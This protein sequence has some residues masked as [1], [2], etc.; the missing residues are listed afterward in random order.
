MMFEAIQ[1]Y[2]LKIFVFIYFPSLFIHIWEQ[3]KLFGVI[4]FFCYSSGGLTVFW[5]LYFAYG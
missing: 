2:L 1:F 3:E 5:K 4:M